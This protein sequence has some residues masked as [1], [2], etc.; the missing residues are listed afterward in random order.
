MN[1]PLKLNRLPGL[2]PTPGLAEIESML[3]LFNSASLLVETRNRRI[4]L[5]NS[6]ATELTAYTRGELSG[7]AFSKLIDQPNMQPFWDLPAGQPFP[8]SLAL[9]KRNG[10]RVSVQAT[11]LELAS[12]GKWVIIQLEE[13]LTIEQRQ[14]QQRRRL[15]MIQSMVTISQ[16]VGQ[17]DL[18]NAIVSIL[19]ASHDITGG[20]SIGV[21]LQELATKGQGFEMVRYAQHGTE[22]AFPERLPAQDMLHLRG[23]NYWIPGKRSASSLHRAAR[24]SGVAF[25]ASAPLGAEG[26]PIGFIAIAGG[27]PVAQSEILPRLEILANM[28][29]ALIQIHTRTANLEASLGDS[30]RAR[31]LERTSMD[32]VEEGVLVL[33]PTLNV[34]HLNPAAEAILGYTNQEARNRPV[35]DILIGTCA[36]ATSLQVAAEGAATINQDDVHLYRRSGTPFLAQVSIVPALMD[37][38]LEGIIVLIRDLSEQE[39]IQAQAEELKQQAVLGELSSIFAHEVRNPINNISTGLQFMA[40]NLPPDDPHQEVISRLQHDCERLDDLMKAVLTIG[41]PAEYKMS[42]VDLGNQ[43]SRLMERFKPRMVNANIQPFLQ[44]EPSL[45]LVSGN[46][47]ALDQ[48]FINLISN[49]I[50]AMSDKGGTLA[51]KLQSLVDGDGKRYVE[52]NV[53]DNGPGI[54]KEVQD[55]LF[56]PF[57]T[58]KKDGNGL[59]LVITR[60]ILNAHKGTISLTGYPGATIFHVHIPVL[61]ST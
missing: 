59:G 46:M 10:N 25:L 37:E 45:P 52:V 29:D 13:V 61:E 1:T 50:E 56:T 36:L 5:A 27:L 34:V 4:L 35:E 30:L 20:D 40:Y 15:G 14:S 2:R 19:E 16:A 57:Y 23:S 32:A 7:M 18:N 41:R 53:A 21:Y 26:A 38:H 47:L 11:R 6:R 12:Q 48:V 9:I 28:I 33:T 31:A 3:E 55:R 60:R 8:A 54:P 51:L 22:N 49:A 42:P 43:A 44:I 39:Q 24:S 17:T 58:T